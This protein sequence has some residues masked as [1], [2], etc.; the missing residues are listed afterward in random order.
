M[1]GDSIGGELKVWRKILGVSKG[2]ALRE[3]EKKGRKEKRKNGGLRGEVERF[4]KKNRENGKRKRILR[5]KKKRNFC[6]LWK[7]GKEIVITGL[8]RIL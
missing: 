3:K 4:L 6:F 2:L 7:E 1:G 8:E 5:K